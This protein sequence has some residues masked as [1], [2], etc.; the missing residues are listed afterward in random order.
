MKLTSIRRRQRLAELMES[1][2]D[3]RRLLA[4]YWAAERE[5]NRIA[6]RLPEKA[7]TFLWKLPGTGY[8]LHHRVLTLVCEHMRFA[9][10]SVG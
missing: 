8:F 2:P 7:R 10:E 9:D 1:D 5:I 6:D 3:G 4:D